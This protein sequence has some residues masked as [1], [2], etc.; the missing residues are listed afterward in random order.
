MPE[1][2]SAGCRIA[3][4]VD[5]PADG[6]V[7]LLCHALSTSAAVWGSQVEALSRRYRV[8]RPDMRGHGR[9][10]APAGEYTIEQLA[11]DAIAVL[12]AERVERAHV[13]GLSIGG[14][15]A[16]WLAIHAAGRVD[17]LVPA[18]TAPRITQ[19]AL[20]TERI[21][22]VRG[23]QL[24]AIADRAME[25]WF[26]EDYRGRHPEVVS[27][28]RAMVTSCVPDGYAGCCA[29]LR[30]TDLTEDLHRVRAAALVVCGM[31]D[32]VTTPSD[33]EAIRSRIPG[34]QMLTLDGAHLPNV[35]RADEFNAALADFL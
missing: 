5:G 10:E 22:Q 20:W 15:I 23:G 24:E 28:H 13:C 1:V 34:A 25:R 33:A 31:W 7:L 21:Q 8:I 27:R 29:V 9:S 2:V 35:E 30:D 26:T 4:D 12:D 3:Y 32:P 16:M 11:A 6:P 18:S 14:L 19:P 17:R